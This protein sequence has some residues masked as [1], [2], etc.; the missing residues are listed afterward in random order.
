MVED[1]LTCAV[2]GCGR[3]SSQHIEGLLRAKNTSIVALCDADVE[4]ARRLAETQQLKGTKLF[5]DYRR[6]LSEVHPN[7]VTIAVPDGEHPA[8]AAAAIEAGAHVLCEKPLALTPESADSMVEMVEGRALQNGVRM[9][10]RFTAS[11]R[12]VRRWIHDG[13]LGKPFHI[14][15]HL[16][17][18]RLSDPLVPIEWRMRRETGGFGA[19]SDLG[20]HMIDLSFFLLDE[21]TAEMR[22]VSGVSIIFYPERLDP[23]T[24]FKDRVTAPDAAVCTVSF[25]SGCVLNL[26]VSR[27]SPGDHFLQIDGSD[28]AVRSNGEEVWIYRREKTE[29]QRPAARFTAVS[30][31]LLR[32]YAEPHLFEEFVRC[33]RTPGMKFSPDFIDGRRVVRTVASI[34]EKLGK[35]EGER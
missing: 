10:Y 28:G 14:R 19:L 26:E 12:F 23:T 4:R 20:A 16:S 2:V 25:A 31:N 30:S 17:V 11:Y 1:H 35:E 5:S 22:N 27:V 24:G 3:I 7:I 32:P 29:H 6:M 21:W 15:A 33:C 8:A 13:N 18:G 34:Y 9:P